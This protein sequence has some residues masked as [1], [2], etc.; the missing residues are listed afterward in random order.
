VVAT[1]GDFQELANAL[2]PQIVNTAKNSSAAV[3]QPGS[4]LLSKISELVR[5]DLTLL[6]KIFVQQTQGEPHCSVG[7]AF[8]TWAD[9]LSLQTACAICYWI[10][11]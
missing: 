6:R 7:E 8:G 2:L 10:S 5:Y 3:R 1:G 11:L 4:R 9:L